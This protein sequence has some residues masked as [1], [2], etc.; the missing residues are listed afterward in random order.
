M[1][2]GLC[3]RQHCD[4]LSTLVLQ[5]LPAVALLGKALC[6]PPGM[7]TGLRRALNERGIAPRHIHFENFEFR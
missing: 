3:T 5:P 7:V 6:G 4:A 1:P 2:H